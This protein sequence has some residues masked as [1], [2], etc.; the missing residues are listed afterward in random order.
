MVWMPKFECVGCGTCCRQ[1][2]DLLPVFDFERESFVGQAKA[3]GVELDVRLERQPGDPD[4]EYPSI[5]VPGGGTVVL[6]Y[7]WNK[8]TD[9]CPMLDAR[10]HCSTWE[11]KLLHCSMYPLP[12][13]PD[14]GPWRCWREYLA[15]P[16]ARA[17][18]PKYYDVLRDYRRAYR[19]VP[20][21]CASAGLV[22]DFIRKVH[23]VVRSLV[24]GIPGAG[25]R[26]SGRRAG[27]HGAGLTD[28]LA[29][30][31]PEGRE[32]KERLAGLTSSTLV[33]EERFL[34]YFGVPADLERYLDAFRSLSARVLVDFFGE[35]DD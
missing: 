2:W 26:G 33:D 25:R 10:G 31:C 35:L 15:S 29:W 21:V 4:L 32:L 22:V 27:E 24:A 9:P 28:V 5:G 23:G 34:E 13:D 1:K 20:A 12:Q 16:R 17:H 11:R 7:V 3:R 18:T 19:W 6:A 14:E 30:A 8:G